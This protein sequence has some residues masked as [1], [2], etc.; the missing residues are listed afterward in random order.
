MP[1]LNGVAI[2][3][4][5]VSIFHGQLETVLAGEGARHNV[6]NLDP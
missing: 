1:P 5:V 3:R 4:R 6:L 2:L